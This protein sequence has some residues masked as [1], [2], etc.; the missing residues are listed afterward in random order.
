[1]KMNRR[2]VLVGLGGLAIG[3]GALFGSGAF[4]Q[5]E[6]ERDV[7]VQTTDDADAL[8]ALEVDDDYEDVTDGV[9]SIDLSDSNLDN[10]DGLNPDAETTF[11]DIL[12]I[13]NNGTQEVEVNISV[14]VDGGLDDLT[15]DPDNFNLDPDGAE[16]EDV[17]M[18][19]DTPADTDTF[20][21]EIL[22]DASSV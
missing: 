8:L 15:F 1:M 3:G 6:A 10:A 22:I 7:T 17:N 5:V 11:E 13:T 9:T 2:N 16:S 21:A 19:V 12:T 18:T 4:D 20:N 14:E